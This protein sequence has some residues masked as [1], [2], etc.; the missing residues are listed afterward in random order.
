MS[1]QK[2]AG[3]IT[4]SNRAFCLKWLLRN[5]L[6]VGNTHIELEG[7]GKQNL[8]NS[9][10]NKGLKMAIGHSCLKLTIFSV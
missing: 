3:W 2:A 5:E 10:P 6:F 8:A 4:R 9:H 7:I 1:L